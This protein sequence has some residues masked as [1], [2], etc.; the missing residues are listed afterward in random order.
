MSFNASGLDSHTL[1]IICSGLEETRKHA[2]LQLKSKS[3]YSMQTKHMQKKVKKEQDRV[4]HLERLMSSLREYDR[5]YN[6]DD[7]DED[8]DMRVQTGDPFS[9]ASSAFSRMGRF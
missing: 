7:D 1:D 8:D 4:K 2:L 9:S 3:S 5:K 6:K